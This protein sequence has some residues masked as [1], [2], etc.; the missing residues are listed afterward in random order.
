MSTVYF[1][2]PR[3]KFQLEKLFALVS[4][5]AFFRS[6]VKLKSKYLNLI[7]YFKT[8]NEESFITKHL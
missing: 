3:K 4:T 6:K 8:K 7:L 1:I 5:V 2:V